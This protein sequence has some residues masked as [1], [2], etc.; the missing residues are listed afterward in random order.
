MFKDVEF[1]FHGAHTTPSG[2]R[3]GPRLHARRQRRLLR[4]AT[5]PFSATDPTSYPSG[6]NAGALGIPGLLIPIAGNP[7]TIVNIIDA[8]PGGIRGPVSA[9]VQPQNYYFNYSFKVQE[10]DYAGYV[11]AHVGGDGWRGNFGVRLV[12][13]DENAYVNIPTPAANLRPRPRP[14]HTSAY[15]DYY[16]DHVH[17]NYFDVLPSANFTFDLQQEPAAAHLGGGDHVAAGLQ[18]AGRHGL[19]DRPHPTGNGGNPNLKPV[20]AAVYD[21][22]LEWYYAPTAVAAVSIFYDDLSS[23]VTYGV[24]NATYSTSC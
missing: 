13:T 11:M 5:M 15:G 9:I 14:H 6:F 12:D 7:S 8:I 20:K 17:H 2:G 21:A 10:N 18:R 1:G 24:H 16:V 22:A 19:A 23:Y 3:L 4:L